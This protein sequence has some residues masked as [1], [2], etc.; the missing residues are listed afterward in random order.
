MKKIVIL[1]IIACTACEQ[2][3]QTSTSADRFIDLYQDR[4]D[5]DAFLEL[6]AEDMV[7]QD[8]ITGYEANGKDAFAAFFNWPDERFQKLHEKTLIVQRLIVQENEAVI[9]GYFTPFIW[10][11]SRVEAMQ[12]TTLLRFNEEQQITLHQDWINYPNDLIDYA[13]RANSNEW[14]RLD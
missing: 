12:F 8:M 13:S 10:D 7:L 6:Y 9:S 5:F 14:I 1:L 3:S 11:S 2:Q 4:T